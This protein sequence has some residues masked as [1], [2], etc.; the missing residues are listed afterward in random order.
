MA[1][2]EKYL[3]LPQ[4]LSD[5]MPRHPLKRAQFEIIQSS[6]ELQYIQH[7]PAVGKVLPR[8][9]TNNVFFLVARVKKRGVD[10][11]KNVGVSSLEMRA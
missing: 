9:V 7:L 8:E 2:T 4:I 6:A 11:E 1:K 10:R 5:F 3:G